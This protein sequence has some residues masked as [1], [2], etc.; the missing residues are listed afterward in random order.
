MFAYALTIGFLAMIFS[1][2]SWLMSDRRAQEEKHRQ[3]VQTMDTAHVYITIDDMPPSKPYKVLGEIKCSEPFAAEEIDQI[4][5]NH[6]LKSIAL[7]KYPTQADAVIKLNYNI[8]YPTNGETGTL[9]VSGQVIQFNSSSDRDLM[10]NMWES[11]AENPVVS[12]R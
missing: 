4:S 8:Q 3:M 6:H 2:C 10:H 1:G 11:P 7:A 5:V 12:P 9:T